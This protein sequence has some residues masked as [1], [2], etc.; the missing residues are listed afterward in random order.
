MEPERHPATDEEL[1]RRS[2]QRD[3]GAFD[4]LVS[5]HGGALLRFAVRTCGCESDGAD[6]LQEGLLAA[7]RSAATFLGHPLR[8]ILS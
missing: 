5:R 7:W 2:A 4:A 1:I 8:E 3:R 6:A